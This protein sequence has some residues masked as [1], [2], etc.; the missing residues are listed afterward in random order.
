M[1]QYAFVDSV[2]VPF[3]NLPEL[4]FEDQLELSIDTL[5]RIFSGDITRWN[6]PIIAQENPSYSLPDEDIILV[7]RGDNSGTTNIFTSGLE[8]SEFWDRGSSNTW[9]SEFMRNTT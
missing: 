4:Q 8:G 2:V 5:A 9:P 3:Y 7:I 1:R 6:D